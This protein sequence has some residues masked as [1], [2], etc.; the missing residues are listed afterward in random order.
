MP[1]LLLAGH[2]GCGNLGDDAIMLGFVGSLTGDYELTLM[3][4]APEVT[5]R[6]YN[7]RSVPRRDFN[8]FK[9]EMERADALVFCGGSVFQDVTS[10]GSVGYYAQLVKIAKKLGK[11]VFMVGQG[12]GPLRGG[13]A[14]GWAR[15]AFNMADAIVCRDPASPAV[16]KSIGVTR[17]VQIGADCA[18]LLTPPPGGDETTFGV[19]TTKTV[20]I[21]PRPYG[22]NPK[23]AIQMFGELA[24]LISQNQMVP[25]MVELDSKFDGPLIMEIGKALGG[26]V[27][28]IR[29]LDTPTQLQSRLARL[30]S[31]ISMRLHGGILAATVG[32]P[33]MMLSY[34]PKVTAFAKM[35][36]FD[37]PLTTDGLTAQR[38]LDSFMQFRKD[39]DRYDKILAQRM[40]EFKKGAMLNVEVVMDSF[41]GSKS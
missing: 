25:V 11:K 14:K 24:R 40:E 9:Y 37:S 4:G 26:K 32:V 21:A 39:R 2:F 5:F 22:K 19:G 31:I 20:G 23:E 35:M 38:V 30:D 3:S 28:E 41:R 34:D 29:K 10:A 7:I 17:P 36:G 8:V 33:A 16:L 13:C 15:N 6:N 1:H 18:F 27:P 12:V